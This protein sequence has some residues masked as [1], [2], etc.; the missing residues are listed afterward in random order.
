M[1]RAAGGHVGIVPGFWAVV[2]GQ[3]DVG[4]R[5]VGPASEGAEERDPVLQVTRYGQCPVT[6]AG[7][8]VVD[9]VADHARLR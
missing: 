7:P 1:Q 6:V 9:V 2:A 5:D 3:L 4:C 8:V